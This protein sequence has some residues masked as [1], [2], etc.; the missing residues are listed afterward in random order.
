MNNIFR[1]S[2]GELAIGILKTSEGVS[3]H[4]LRDKAK[5]KRLLSTDCALFTFMGERLCDSEKV[6]VSSDKDWGAASV[7]RTENGFTI[8]LSGNKV[9]PNVTVT[10]TAICVG[11]SI[12]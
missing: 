9:I 8:V 6:I 2:A 11:N 4:S 7:I 5:G 10:L 12:E 1:F 3:L